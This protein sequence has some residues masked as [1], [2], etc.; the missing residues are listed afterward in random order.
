MRLRITT[1][2]TG[3]FYLFASVQRRDGSWW[4]WRWPKER[5]TSTPEETDNEFK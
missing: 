3:G 2:G 1:K 4:T 5:K